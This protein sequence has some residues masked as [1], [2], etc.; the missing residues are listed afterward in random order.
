[1]PVKNDQE[2]KRKIT[3]RWK[4]IAAAVEHQL[5]TDAAMAFAQLEY[6]FEEAGL[7]IKK[8]QPYKSRKTKT[9]IGTPQ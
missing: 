4:I 5:D 2:L 7:L 1:M 9:E 6:I 3:D 8:R